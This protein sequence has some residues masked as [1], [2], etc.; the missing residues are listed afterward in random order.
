VANRFTQFSAKEFQDTI[1]P[2]P[3]G[4]MMQMGQ[5]NQGR[6]DAMNI[7]LGKAEAGLGLNAGYA[8]QGE[9]ANKV[10]QDYQTKFNAISDAYATDGNHGAAAKGLSKFSQERAADPRIKLI[11]SDYDTKK[12]VDERI[13]AK[14]FG[15]SSRFGAHDDKTGQWN[16][17]DLEA[18][19]GRGEMITGAHYNY[20][21]NQGDF[22]TYSPYIDKITADINQTYVIDPTDGIRKHKETNEV[23]DYSTILG[24]SSPLLNRVRNDDGSI[25]MEA[26]TALDPK[27]AE[28]TMWKM[29]ALAK[30]NR[31]YEHDGL[32][33]DYMAVAALS[34]KEINKEDGSLSKSRKDIKSQQEAQESSGLLSGPHSP[35]PYTITTATNDPS[36]IIETN[37]QAARALG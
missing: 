11:Q 8:T 29:E 31:T 36:A 25:N 9:Y 27:M 16:V 19:A 20:M 7:A 33:D 28:N 1:D 24:K 35:T 5:I 6:N 23:L 17:G 22:K 26:L 10:E 34:F 15:V 37:G 21:E 32:V 30:E 13:N 12:F 14:G 4:A 18:M 2:L 3:I